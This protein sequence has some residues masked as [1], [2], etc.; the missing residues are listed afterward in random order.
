MLAC[1]LTWVVLLDLLRFLMERELPKLASLC[2]DNRRIT[3]VFWNK[4][5][6]LSLCPNSDPLI[7]HE[8]SAKHY[9]PGC[10]VFLCCHSP[11]KPTPTVRSTSLGTHCWVFWTSRAGSPTRWGPRHLLRQLSGWRGCVSYASFETLSYGKI[12]INIKRHNVP[13]HRI[14]Q[15]QQQKELNTTFSWLSPCVTNNKTNQCIY[16]NWE[17]LTSWSTSTPGSLHISTY[18]ST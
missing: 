8:K 14:Q 1:W 9:S 10:C 12:D 17:D 7:A 16:Y 3:F 13:H 18:T 5:L 2:G 6:R 4:Q 11:Q 15:E